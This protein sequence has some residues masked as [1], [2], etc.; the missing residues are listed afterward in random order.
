MCGIFG[1]TDFKK[2][3]LKK[4]R[5]SLNTLEHRGPDQWSDYF[6]E[7]VYMGHQRLSILDLSDHGRQP[8]LNTEENIII[9]VNGEIYNF[10]D[11]KKE[12]APKYT[13]KSTSDS[14]VVLYGYIEWGIDKLLEKIDGMYAISIYDKKDNLLFLARDRVGIK[15]LYFGN[16]NNQICWASE[17]KAIQKL[18]ENK[19]ILEYDYTAFYDFLTYLYVPTPKSMY[20]NIFKL[21]PAHYLKIDTK[22]NKFKKVKYWQLDIKVCNDDI[23]T[24]KKKIYNLVKKSVGEQMV[25]DVPVGFFLSGGMDSSTVVALAAK[26]HSDINTFSIGFTDKNHDETHFAELVADMYKTK[27]H[28]KILDEKTT[29]DMFHKIKEWYDEP[30]GDT[31]CFPT[32]MVSKFAKENSTVVL[33]GDGGDEVFGGYNWYKRFENLQKYSLSYFRFLK[34]FTIHFKKQNNILGKVSKRLESQFLLNDVELYT[35]LMGGM[36]KDEKEKYKKLWD[37]DENYDDY[38]Y[39]KKF[40][41]KDLDI[42]TRLQYLDFHTYLHD[43]ILTKVD[44]VSMA[45]SLECRIP[46]LSKEI[47]EYSFSLEK[48]VRIYKD[49]LKG[50]M[51]EAFKDNLPIEIIKRDKKG[52]S[53]PLH[54][55]KDLIGNKKT[56][57]EK[58]LS[59]FQIAND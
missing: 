13:F 5:K 24:A 50:V 26:N 29:R 51:K 38:W 11:L 22:T 41:R 14:E 57:Q 25:A 21:E 3:D 46:F 12:L 2:Q 32:Y 53:I 16:I 30:F 28:K 17:L 6:D 44:R 31:S 47:I 19:N 8:M 39:F 35:R 4:A 49:E 1:F 48:E 40:Y 7:D 33:T 15:P 27:H 58:I 9:S 43:D 36:L 55:W 52:L 34:V 59:Y 37:I 18:Y 42:Y 56:K 10:L 45:V 20:K 23:E 54:S